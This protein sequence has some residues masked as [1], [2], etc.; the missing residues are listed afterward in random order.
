NFLANMSHEIR[1]PLN[2]VLGM[3]DQLA[4][5]RL[6]AHQQRLLGLMQRSGQHLLAV[7]N[8]VL[9]M[10]KISAGKLKMEQVAFDLCDSMLAAVQPLAAQA[11]AKGLAFRGV[12]L[13]I[14]CPYPWVVGD[15]HRL[16]QILINLVSNAVKFTEHGSIE[17]VGEM[18]GETADTLTVRFRVSDTGMGIPADK[19]EHIFESFAQAQA[20]TARQY[21]GTGLGLSISR[22]LVEQ[23]GGTLTLASE[24]GRGSTFAFTVTLP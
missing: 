2:G 11:A 18:L 22:A 23:L 13:R 10:A 8:D 6:D 1:T 9:D 14:S 5:T 4:T 15:A 20:G 16:N 24:E 7:L 17:V 21:G 3:A 19:L 12:P